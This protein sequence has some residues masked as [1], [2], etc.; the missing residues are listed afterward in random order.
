MRIESE[1]RWGSIYNNLAKLSSSLFL[2]LLIK[3][4]KSNPFLLGNIIMRARNNLGNVVFGHC[5]GV[6]EC[7]KMCEYSI[8]SPLI[9]TQTH[10]GLICLLRTAYATLG[11]WMAWMKIRPYV[12][13]EQTTIVTTNCEEVPLM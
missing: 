4:I 13:L 1:G 11:R 12:A 7:S 5:S 3:G 10:I 6:F 9:L 8:M 2:L